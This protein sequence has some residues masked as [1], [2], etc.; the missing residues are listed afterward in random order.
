MIL[1]AM[2][3]YRKRGVCRNSLQVTHYFYSRALYFPRTVSG[4]S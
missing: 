4:L 3:R 1:L 2:Y